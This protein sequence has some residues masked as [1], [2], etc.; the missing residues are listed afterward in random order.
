MCRCGVVSPCH[1]V[2]VVRCLYADVCLRCRYVVVL[3]CGCVGVIQRLLM[4]GIV[5]LWLCCV[6]V[7]LRGSVAVLMC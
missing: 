4:C 7:V 6:D 2:D 5:T 1:C 3:C